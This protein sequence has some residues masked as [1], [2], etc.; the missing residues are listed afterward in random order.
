MWLKAS[1]AKLIELQVLCVHED[2]SIYMLGFLK[3]IKW[4]NI[5][6]CAYHNIYLQLF[7][8]DLV[9]FCQTFN[10]TWL[11]ECHYVEVT[12]FHSL[13]YLRIMLGNHKQNKLLLFYELIM[14][15]LLMWFLRTSCASLNKKEKKLTLRIYVDS[16]IQHYCVRTVLQYPYK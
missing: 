11:Y 15:L 12:T 6:K 2:Y 1:Q 8:K 5:S 16:V 9:V 13:C 4:T 10:T 14:Q 7:L 3:G